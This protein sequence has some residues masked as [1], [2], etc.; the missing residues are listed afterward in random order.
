MNTFSSQKQKHRGHTP[1][2]SGHLP[3]KAGHTREKPS[4]R[5]SD[6]SGESPLSGAFFSAI[7]AMPFVLVIGCL[8]LLISTLAAY[9]SPNPHTLILP[10]SLTALGLTS[11]CGGVI[12]AR[13]KRGNPLLGGLFCGL[14]INLFLLTASLFFNDGDSEALSLGLSSLARWGLHAAVV[15]LSTVGARLGK[16]K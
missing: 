5:S 14:L 3:P 2:P 9:R 12:S 4:V 16:G 15:L 6:H 10:L 13:R 1:P 8:F 11:L 7:F